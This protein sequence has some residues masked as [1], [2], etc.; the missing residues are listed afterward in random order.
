VNLI[1]SLAPLACYIPLAF[2]I[3]PMVFHGI[4]RQ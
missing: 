3:A 1:I 2:I 4:E